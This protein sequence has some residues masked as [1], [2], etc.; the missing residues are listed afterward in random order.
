M[1]QN[2]ARLEQRSVDLPLIASARRQYERMCGALPP[3]RGAGTSSTGSMARPSSMARPATQSG[4]PNPP[5]AD[6]A[7]RSTN[8]TPRASADQAARMCSLDADHPMCRGATQ[9][10]RLRSFS[11]WSAAN[12]GR[13]AQESTPGQPRDRDYCPRTLVE[14]ALQLGLVSSAAVERCRSQWVQNN[15]N[16][17]EQFAIYTCL[18]KASHMEGM[19][20]SRILSSAPETV[21]TSLPSN[22]YRQPAAMAAIHAGNFSQVPPI[23]GDGTYFHQALGQ[24]GE[25]CPALGV[26]AIQLQMTQQLVRRQQEVMARAARGQVTREEAQSIVA[27]IVVGMVMMENCDAKDSHEERQRCERGKED[28]MT[29]PESRDAVQDASLLVKRHACTS[30]ET[31]RF[32]ANLGKW[33][34]MPPEMR[35]PLAWADG[36]REQGRYRAIFENCRRQG[37]DGSADAWC[38]CYV[39]QF[40]KTKPGT[41]AH[42]AEHAATASQTAFVGDNDSWFV[43]SQLYDCE[44]QLEQLKVWRRAQ[45]PEKV[46]ACLVGQSA[47]AESV[48][49]ELK[50]CRY[51]AAWGE[52]EVRS[53]QCQPQLLAR[54]WGGETVRCN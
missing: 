16:R 24:L 40:S 19:M 13:C 18:E 17:S 15:E 20:T 27:S 37:G 21:S 32:T 43:P 12:Y 25:M 35:S 4:A 9:A 36:D 10:P 6:S 47:V 26:E 39:R 33:L 38:G 2:L 22:G 44:P 42:P 31:R 45:A 52:I 30:N 53:Q 54:N 50:A 28:L 41:R 34:M 48:L 14:Q 11:Y 7:S 29:L 3:D 49:P 8:A 5:S 46:T 51:R 1:S 23:R